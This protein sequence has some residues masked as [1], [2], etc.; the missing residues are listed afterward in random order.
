MNRR[1]LLTALLA[2]PF[3][4]MFK[5]KKLSEAEQICQLIDEGIVRAKLHPEWKYDYLWLVP[6]MAGNVCRWRYIRGVD[7]KLM[8]PSEKFPLGWYKIH[9]RGLVRAVDARQICKIV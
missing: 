7:A 9:E 4:W 5:P 2:A 6:S 1:Q 8:P 3:A